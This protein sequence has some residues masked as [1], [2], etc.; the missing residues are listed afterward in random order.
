[1]TCNDDTIL[2]TVE[3]GLY[4]KIAILRFEPIL[5]WCNGSIA[6]RLEEDVRSNRTHEGAGSNHSKGR[7]I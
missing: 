6:S 7:I 4:K 5:W 2:R 3:K 1:M